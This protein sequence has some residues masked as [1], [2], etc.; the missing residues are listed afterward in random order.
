M[1]STK[2]PASAKRAAFPRAAAYSKGFFKDWERLQRSGRFNMPLLKQAMLM[3]IAN[4]APLPA[5]WL[6]HALKA[7]WADH[8]EC[9]IG[10]DFLLIYK[11]EGN[12]IH[13]VRT[14]TH[15]ELFE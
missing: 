6:D 10:R 12:L 1:P 11:M 15:A 2:K 14:G 9:H 3:L 5:E 4:D 7:D 13:F 8:R